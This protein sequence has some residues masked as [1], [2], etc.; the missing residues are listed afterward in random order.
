MF[1]G[2]NSLYVIYSSYT[3]SSSCTLSFFFFFSEE[4]KFLMNSYVKC[5]QREKEIK[6]LSKGLWKFGCDLFKHKD[7]VVETYL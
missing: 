2:V 6:Y 1:T 3:Y 4:I 7:F 5:S